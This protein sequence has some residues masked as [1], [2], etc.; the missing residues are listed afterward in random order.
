MA[1]RVGYFPHNNSLFVLRHRGILE[2]RLPDVEWV[3][4]RTLPQS[5]RVDPK[6]GLPSLHSDWLFTEGGY[7]FIGTGF[8]PP[9]T[10]LA[11]GRDLV[12]VGIS[13]PRVENGRLVTKA[14]SGI[15]TAA[16]LQGKRVGIAHGSWQTTLLLFALEKAGLTWSDVEPIDTDV[17][18]GGDALLAGDLD[19][20]VGAYP[21][22]TAVEAATELHTLVDTESVFSHPSLWFT[23][24]D[25]A[26][27]H[28]PELEA[29]IASLQESDAW[30]TANPR[31][32]AQYFVDDVT[33][34]GGRA[35]LDAWEA[36][37]R[38]RPFGVNAVTEEFL[39]EQQRAADLLAANGLLSRTIRVRDAVLSW[40]GEAVEATKSGATV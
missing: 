7:D 38:G 26:E 1:L 12:Y 34:R 23:R 21:G 35:D 13:G 28:R 17:R 39:D 16:D 3:D 33:A 37:L 8:T 36:A 10:G 25:I 18:D 30:I 31:A 27:Q 5:E 11:N 15:R 22:L 4:L 19:A 32:A 40:I 24:R 9:I 29:I 2:T 14:D 6:T 20:W